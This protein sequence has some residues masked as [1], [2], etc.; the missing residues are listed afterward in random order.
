MVTTD[1]QPKAQLM[2]TYFEKLARIFWVSE[3]YLF[4]AYAW[5][6]FFDLSVKQNKALSEDDR[7]AMASAVL[8]AAMAIP[9]Y[10]SGAPGGQQ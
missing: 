4:H 2:A 6:K 3:N 10:A 7:R 9:N 1:V 5:Y 8:L